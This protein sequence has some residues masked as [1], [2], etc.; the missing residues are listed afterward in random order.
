M[1][2]LWTGTFGNNYT[3]R[4]AEVRNVRQR[5][6]LWQAML[7][8]NC[9]SIF[10]Q[11]CPV[12]CVSFWTYRLQKGLWRWPAFYSLTR[13]YDPSRFA[14]DADII[15]AKGH[16]A[17]SAAPQTAGTVVPFPQPH[18]INARRGATPADIA[19][20]RKQIDLCFDLFASALVNLLGNLAENLPLDANGEFGESLER[21]ADL[22][23][24][25]IGKLERL[26][27]RGL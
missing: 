4:N 9:Q 10:N 24:E 19:Y 15:D 13:K 22:R 18:H 2:D 17:S 1:I 7:P 11:G 3:K 25:V 8:N 27:D 16:R 23:G 6:A 5:E 12:D 26:E 20:T 14:L 21:L